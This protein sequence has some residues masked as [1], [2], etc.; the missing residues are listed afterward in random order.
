MTLTTIEAPGLRLYR[1]GKV[2]DTFELGD[3]TLLM[4]ASDR[5]SA[6]DVV[7]PTAIGGKGAVL[8]QM[9]RWWF[10]RTADLVPNHLLD[11][12][13]AEVTDGLD[14][15]VL[16]PR[17]MRVARAERIDVECVVRGFLAGSGWQE[18]K[19]HGTLAGEPLPPGLLES[20]A[21]PEPRFTPAVKN[22]SGHDQNISRAQL[23]TLIGSELAA[24]LERVSLTLFGFASD[25]CQHTG[26]I[27]VDTKFEFGFI[28]GRLTL[29]D[30]ALTPDSSRFWEASAWSAGRSMPSYD[31]QPVRDW[32]TSQPWDRTAPGP[33]L[34]AEVVAA[35]SSRYA[36]AARRI[37]GL[38]LES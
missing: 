27:L 28:D 1:R 15:P 23:A 35:T 31:K 19:A 4:V 2:R 16:R 12:P 21:L 33:E 32:L 3:G 9:S 6:F 5:I 20:S 7:L 29:I 26:M 36:E 8:T 13:A 22:D 18:Y 10:G 14:W 34:P 37:C 24:D 25:H 30:E 11:D 38:D 17:S